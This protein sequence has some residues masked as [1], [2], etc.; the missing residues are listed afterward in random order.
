MAADTFSWQLDPI[1]PKSILQ[2]MIELK[3]Y[4]N[5]KERELKIT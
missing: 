5:K 1:F 2:F 4:Y 3:D